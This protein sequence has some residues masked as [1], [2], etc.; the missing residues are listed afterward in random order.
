MSSYKHVIDK[1]CKAYKIPIN[2]VWSSNYSITNMDIPV[3]FAGYTTPQTYVKQPPYCTLN[4]TILDG[5][6]N[7]RA[8]DTPVDDFKIVSVEYDGS[9]K[10][11]LEV[12]FIL[13]E[14]VPAIWGK[15]DEDDSITL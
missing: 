15:E 13:S 10:I 11:E 3:I 7:A 1:F 6:V 5:M 9:G 4:I 12:R 2:A 14:E 8:F